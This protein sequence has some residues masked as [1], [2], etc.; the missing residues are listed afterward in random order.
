LSLPG[1]LSLNKFRRM[2]IGKAL[3]VQPIPYDLDH[4]MA[5]L[6]HQIGNIERPL[7]CKALRAF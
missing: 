2:F 6:M 5:V 1:Y 7:L 4:C 3:D